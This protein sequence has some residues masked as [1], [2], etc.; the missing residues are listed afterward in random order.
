MRRLPPGRIT[1]P[2]ETDPQLEGVGIAPRPTLIA[3]FQVDIETELQLTPPQSAVATATTPVLPRDSSEVESA[4]IFAILPGWHAGQALS[5]VGE[6][7]TT[8]AEAPS[9]PPP[10]NSLRLPP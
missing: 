3:L 9:T 7:V 2:A 6:S 4:T 5:L 10:A 8:L 1:L